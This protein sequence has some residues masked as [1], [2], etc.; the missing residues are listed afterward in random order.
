[1]TLMAALTTYYCYYVVSIIQ[2]NQGNALVF[3]L[4]FSAMKKIL[5][6]GTYDDSH[7][8]ARTHE[9]WKGG[10]YTLCCIA[11]PIHAR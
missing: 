4:Y 5:L 7:T 11:A 3:F 8:Y 10:G 2:G 1:M 6:F 9:A